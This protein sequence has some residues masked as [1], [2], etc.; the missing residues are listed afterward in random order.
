MP[1]IFV[2]ADVVLGSSTVRQITGVDHKTGQ[3]HRKAMN[4]GGVA[5]VQ[6]SGKKA[7]EVS[8]LTS[9]DLATLVAL[10][11]NAF[12]SAGLSLASSTITIPYKPRVSGGSFVSG[13]NFV[14]LTGANAF[15]V[16]TSFEASEDG[17]FATCGFDVHWLSTDGVTKGC[18]DASSQA[19]AS[20]AFGAEYTLGPCYINGTLV[21]G[22]QSLR[23]TPGI[24]VVKPP[25]GSGSIFPTMASI[26]MTTPTIELT[27]NDFA[28]IA[29]TVGDF[30]A[31]TSAN[32][33]MKK[34][35]D[36]GVFTSAATTEHVRFTFAAGLADTGGVT[37]S[38]NDDGSA[39]I[40]LHGKVLTAS[41]A[42]ALP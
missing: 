33:Y 4:S 12:C 26:K 36:S 15:I 24:E 32:C 7:A 18:D 10:N 30:T 38:N 11:T 5:V 21:A 28:A 39:T 6:V 42:V 27:V 40:T 37:V 31:M 25:L 34:R 22:V 41:A 20:Q 29:G 3:E 8:S 13:S 17:D 19:L 14:A 9:A 2:P 23:V 1:T 16:P 35:A